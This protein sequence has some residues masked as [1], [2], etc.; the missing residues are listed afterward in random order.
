MLKR[1]ADDRCGTNTKSR[2]SKANKKQKPEILIRRINSLQYTDF[3]QTYVP[4][5]AFSYTP[6]TH[7]IPPNVQ[8]DQHAIG[9]QFDITLKL[10]PSNSA[11]PSQP[12]QI[13]SLIH[14]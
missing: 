5:H 3:V 2:P 4:S 14:I 12:E 6:R 13:L 7:D 10:S 11:Q 8:N 9:P 1:K